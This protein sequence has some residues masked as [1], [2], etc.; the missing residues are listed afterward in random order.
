MIKKKREIP[1]VF[2][3]S[4]SWNDCQR[5]PLFIENFKKLKYKNFKFV[6]VDNNSKDETISYVSTQLT[7]STIIRNLK[8]LGTAGGYNVGYKYALKHDC[9]YIWNLAIDVVIDPDCLDALIEVAE[10]DKSIGIVGPIT[11]YSHD[12]NRIESYGS[13]FEVR[14]YWKRENLRGILE[15]VSKPQIMDVGYTDGG[16]ALI[17]RQVFEVSGLIDDKLFM[18][19]EDSDLCLRAQKS[20]FRTVVTERAKVWHRHEE[21][22][23]KMPTRF[24]IFY[25]SRNQLYI[26]KKHSSKKDWFLTILRN[27]WRTPRNTWRMFI[28]IRFDLFLAYSLG[29]IYGVF[30]L[31]GRRLYVR[32]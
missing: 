14:R 27:L 7:N 28:N 5:L 15:P 25:A 9:D 2:I 16:S 4:V 22:R 26:V 24:A 32:K 21:L 30:G 29:F 20:G 17:R 10:S 6:M 1:K 11:Y 19:C 3:I 18:Y 13:I 12:K 31:M 23:G 8:N